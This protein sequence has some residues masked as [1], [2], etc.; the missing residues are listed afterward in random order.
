MAIGL[1][2]G[3]PTLTALAAMSSQTCLL[4]SAIATLAVFECDAGIFGAAE[5]PQ[6]VL[7]HVR[8]EFGH[9][10]GNTFIRPG[11]SDL[12]IVVKKDGVLH[13][14]THWRDGPANFWAQFL[15]YPRRTIGLHQGRFKPARSDFAPNNFS[16]TKQPTE[17][18]N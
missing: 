10:G 4:S 15:A 2:S 18:T 8:A 12:P 13:R 14:R 16:E 1:G 7:L 3:P 11:A 9:D 6:L 5:V 17:K